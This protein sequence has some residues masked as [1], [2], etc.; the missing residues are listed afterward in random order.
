MPFKMMQ[1]HSL[2][3]FHAAVRLES[4]PGADL[5]T[6][7]KVIFSLFLVPFRAQFL[8]FLKAWRTAR[9]D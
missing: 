6:F 7:E 9:S 5:S 1:K 3:I 4:L 2:S 8:S